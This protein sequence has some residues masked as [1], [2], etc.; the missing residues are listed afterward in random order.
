MRGSEVLA[1]TFGVYEWRPT[2]RFRLMS[3]MDLETGDH[4]D[5]DGQAWGCILVTMLPIYLS[6]LPVTQ[7][8][9]GGRA[10]TLPLPV[11]AWDARFWSGSLHGGLIRRLL[12]VL[13]ATDAMRWNTLPLSLDLRWALFCW[14]RGQRSVIKNWRSWQ[15][16]R[17]RHT[18]FSV[19]RSNYG[20][21]EI[22]S[23]TWNFHQKTIK[24]PSKDHQQ[25]KGISHHW[26]VAFTENHLRNPL[27]LGWIVSSFL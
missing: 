1:E 20:S 3:S 13:V 14:A 22:V 10:I 9:T 4:I 12:V 24:R 26:N 7:G 5:T 18:W 11:P 8:T 25:R 19:F 27:V 15:S 16:T 17:D 23:N 21:W 6:D 2:V